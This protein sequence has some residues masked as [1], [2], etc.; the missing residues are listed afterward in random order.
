M[1]LP[2]SWRGDPVGP[3]VIEDS[4]GLRLMHPFALDAA[5]LSRLSRD[6][7]FRAYV[8]V[9]MS[10]KRVRKDS[11]S[12]QCATPL[13]AHDDQT[14]RDY[15]RAVAGCTYRIEGFWTAITSVRILP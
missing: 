5:R 7:G 9:T 13:V 3:A 4:Y 2:P 15:G 1:M 10:Y 11:V 12:C 8:V 6:V 14:R